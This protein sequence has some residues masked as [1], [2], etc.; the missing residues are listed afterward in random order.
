MNSVVPV[1]TN[2]E[3]L[4]F[5]LTVPRSRRFLALPTR[6][7]VPSKHRFYAII[8]T[9]WF[10]FKTLFKST[11]THV[12]GLPSSGALLRQDSNKYFL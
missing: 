11:R 12:G 10:N 3:N 5:A 9:N 2:Y 4:L 6:L 1:P 8:R 7:F